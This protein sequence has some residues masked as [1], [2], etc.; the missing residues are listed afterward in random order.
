MASGST[1]TTY[2][3]KT[4]GTVV[5]W[6]WNGEAQLGNGTRGG[7]CTDPTTPNCVAASPV[8][9]TGLTGVTDVVGGDGYALAL[10]SD[11]TAYG[12]GYAPQGQTGNS[13][14][15]SVPEPVAGQAGVTALGSGGR[16]SYLV[17]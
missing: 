15:A 16:A 14:T 6:G 10:R 7:V 8:A 12:W 9:V 17:R 3:T 11:G 2:A 4:D 5:A 13:G 1:S